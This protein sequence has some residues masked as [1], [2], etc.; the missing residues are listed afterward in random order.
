MSWCVLFESM[1][2]PSVIL[3]VFCTL[4]LG[5]SPVPIAIW[6]FLVCMPQLELRAVVNGGRYREYGADH[7]GLT[8]WSVDHC[9]L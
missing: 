6:V 8:P 7:Y 1:L 2:I 9:L 3:A 4:G 5:L